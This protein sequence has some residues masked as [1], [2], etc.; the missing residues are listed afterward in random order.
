MTPLLYRL[1]IAVLID[2]LTLILVPC[3]AIQ[4]QLE[5]WRATIQ[6]RLDNIQNS[7][8]P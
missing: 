6:T 2:I 3:V 4:Q 5:R 8:R 7:R 1:A